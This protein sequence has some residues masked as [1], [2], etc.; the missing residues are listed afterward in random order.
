[1]LID[2]SAA[3]AAAA[4]VSA[5]VSSPGDQQVMDHLVE[6][7]QLFHPSESRLHLVAVMSF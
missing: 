7:A 5:S 6:A 4:S 1:M 2:V 3:A